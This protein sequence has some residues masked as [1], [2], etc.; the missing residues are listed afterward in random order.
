MT[1]TC[2]SGGLAAVEDRPRRG[3]LCFQDRPVRDIAVPLHQRRDRSALPDDDLEQFPYGVCDRAIMTVDQQY[4]SL[5]VVLFGM[6]GE[7]NLADAR[8]RKI[9]EIFARREAVI[10]GGYEDIVDV[11]Q[12]AASGTPGNRADEV[13]LAHRRFAKGEIG[14]WVFKQER[15][16]DRLLHFVDMIADPAECRLGVGQRQ[17]IVEIDGLMRR[18][19]EMLGDQ[20]RLVARNEVPEASQMRLV[21]RLRSAD[22][23][24]HAVQ[25]HRMVAPYGFERAMRWSARAHIVLGMDFEEAALLAFREDR[26]KMLVLEARAREAADR[27]DWKAKRNC[28]RRRWPGRRIHLSS[29]LSR[30]PCCAA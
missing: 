10:G 25:R 29:P 23:H 3:C 9:R 7:M 5:V 18:P 19:G 4:V 26:G 28:R 1:I 11:E 13:R 20:R 8:E 27:H 21:E 6:T 24:A 15:P 12:Q 14:R 2:G 17:Q 22:R 16:A 30:H